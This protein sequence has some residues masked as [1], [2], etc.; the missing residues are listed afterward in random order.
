[1]SSS[2]QPLFGAIFDWDGVIIDSGALHAQSWRLL[3]TELGK[4]I[5]PDSFI[6]GFG[7][8]SARIIAEI[9]GWARDPVEIARL[10]IARKRSIGRSWRGARSPRCPAW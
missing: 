7:M 1:M 10:R 8:K 2:A 6:R 4:E 3:A 5:A 9:H